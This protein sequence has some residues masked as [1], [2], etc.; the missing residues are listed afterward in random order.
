MKNYLTSKKIGDVY[1]FYWK[2]MDVTGLFIN[3]FSNLTIEKEK[4]CVELFIKRYGKI[5]NTDVRN[6]KNGLT[7]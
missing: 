1:H 7:N 2:K 5:L 3:F 4:Y 6:R